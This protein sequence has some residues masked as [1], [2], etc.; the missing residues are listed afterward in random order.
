MMGGARRRGMTRRIHRGREGLRRRERRGGWIGERKGTE[1]NGRGR[2]WRGMAVE[3]DGIRG[4][5]V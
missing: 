5:A 4:L 3:G 1:G 2:R